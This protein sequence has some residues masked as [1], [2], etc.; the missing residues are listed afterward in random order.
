MSSR[1]LPV[2]RVPIPFLDFVGC[3]ATAIELNNAASPTS[4]WGRIIQRNWQAHSVR[5]FLSTAGKKRGINIGS[6][7]N[8]GERV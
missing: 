5:G 2:L 4:T 6:E 7:K 1:G 3:C 8:A